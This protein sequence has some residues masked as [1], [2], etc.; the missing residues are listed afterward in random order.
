MDSH[1][2]K[3]LPHYI[4]SAIHGRKNI[5]PRFKIKKKYPSLITLDANNAF[6]HIAGLKAIEIGSKIVNK[7]GICAISVINST[8]PGAMA[9]IALR[10]AEK[11]LICIALTH[12]DALIRST[13]G[14]RAFFGTNPIC[15]AAP[16]AEKFPYCLD[17]STSVIS[18]NKL[19]GMRKISKKSKN[20]YGSNVFG[21]DTN[22][23]K[24]IVSLLPTGNYKGFALASMVEVLCGI[25]SGMDFGRKIK[26]MYTTSIKVKRN[27]SQFYI[28]IKV[29]GTISKNSF[30][31]RMQLLTKQVR[32]EPRLNRKKSVMLPND[33]EIKECKIRLSKGIPLSKD[34]FI[35]LKKFSKKFNIKFLN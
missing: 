2:I 1:G 26:P 10:A 34:L 27:L 18:W 5:K 32:K 23:L 24:D 31:K 3:L 13:N 11:G 7:F 4:N 28:L 35:E 20:T 22:N 30:L 14:K 19:L 21:K 9:S 12:A 8:H 33:P 29:D 6:G 16:R 25:Y 15:V 17:M